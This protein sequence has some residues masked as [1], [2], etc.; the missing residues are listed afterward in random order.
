MWNILSHIKQQHGF[1]I[2]GVGDWGQLPLVDEEV[3]ALDQ[4]WVVK[5]IFNTRW[6]ELTKLQR[7]NE[8]QPLQDAYRARMGHAIDFTRYGNEEHEL[9]LCHTSD[10]KQLVVDGFENTKHIINDGLREMA[11]RTHQGNIFMNSVEVE[12]QSWTGN[13]LKLKKYDKDTIETDM[14]YT[15]RFKPAFAMACHMAQGSTFTRPSNIY[16]YK[17]MKPRLL[18]FTITRARNNKQVNCCD[19]EWYKPYTGHIDRY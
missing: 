3:T 4:P 15:T 13:T 14:K 12:I 10:N 1:I 5:Y 17:T 16:E 9:A 6:Y 18:R 2:S 7:F 19:G 8:C 11:Y